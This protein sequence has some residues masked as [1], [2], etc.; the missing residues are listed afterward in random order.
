MCACVGGGGRMIEGGTK[1]GQAILYHHHLAD[2]FIL[3]DSG[4]VKK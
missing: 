2:A 3:S 1:G 4:E